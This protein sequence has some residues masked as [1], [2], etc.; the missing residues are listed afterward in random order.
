MPA[1]QQDR[2]RRGGSAARCGGRAGGTSGELTGMGA[3]AEVH[4][5][6]V[7]PFVGFPNLNLPGQAHSAG[8]STSRPTTAATANPRSRT[9]SSTAGTSLGPRPREDRRWSAGRSAGRAANR[10]DRPARARRSRSWPS[11]GRTR[12]CAPRRGPRPRP[13]PAGQGG[14]LDLPPPAPDPRH[15]S[16]RCP[17]RPKPV[18][19]VMAWT[20][21][22][23]ASSALTALSWVVEA[24]MAA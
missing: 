6:T 3:S 11:C 24:I 19:S 14:G 8:P 5:Q 1:E 7:R 10:R 17:S 16:R 12:R 2:R 13:R 21:R 20:P 22:S 9:R 4:P 23:A 15:I 18:T